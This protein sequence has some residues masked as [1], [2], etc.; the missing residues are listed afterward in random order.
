MSPA[1]FF[2]VAMELLELL[3]ASSFVLVILGL[4]LRPLAAALVYLIGLGLGRFRLRAGGWNVGLIISVPLAF[5]VT[6][7]L[8]YLDLRSSAP[9]AAPGV[10]AGVTILLVL[11]ALLLTGLYGGLAFL[12][13]SEAPPDHE[14]CLGHFDRGALVFLAT[15]FLAAATGVADPWPLRLAVPWLLASA[16]ALGSARLAR[17]G[18][19]SRRPSSAHAA[20]LAFALALALFAEASVLLSPLLVEP[21]S[22]AQKALG[23]GFVE[24]L[25]RLGE[26]LDRIFVA[27]KGLGEAPIL[28]AA[29]L[30]DPERAAKQ[31]GPISELVLV[32]LG[33][34]AV[35]VTLFVLVVTSARFLRSLRHGPSPLRGGRPLRDALRRLLSLLSGLRS[36]LLARRGGAGEG[37]GRR[38]GK[39]LAAYARLLRGGRAVRA[40]RR[41]AETPREYGERLLA[42]HP[43]AARDAEFI[44]TMMEREVWAGREPGKAEARVLDA[45]RRRTGPAAF[46]AELLARALRRVL[47][48]RRR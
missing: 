29:D 20:L 15:L 7:A 41:A 45:A 26:F 17:S 19:K 16:L 4:P 3:A 11:V 2:L 48:R 40:G 33:L 42:A 31:G 37:E 39:A 38:F 21:A 30:V 46:R 10:E 23:E 28:R 6:A 18:R 13:G 43:G 12:R 35:G 32:I 47:S 5:V 9:S 22:R 36:R 8:F 24:G 1:L 25:A 34:G 14:S 27:P 44:I